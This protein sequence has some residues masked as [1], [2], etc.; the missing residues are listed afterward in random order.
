MSVSYFVGIH[1]RGGQLRQ[2]S[3]L[4]LHAALQFYCIE[5]GTVARD[6]NGPHDQYLNL[7]ARIYKARPL[8]P[9]TY[10]LPLPPQ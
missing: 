9:P 2:V 7:L 8:G 4:R 1:R 5:F 6:K 3:G 10:P